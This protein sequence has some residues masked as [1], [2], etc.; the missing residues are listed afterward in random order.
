MLILALGS[1]ALAGCGTT[2]HHHHYHGGSDPGYARGGGYQH[3]R[4]RN[5]SYRRSGQRVPDPPPPR[6]HT[7]H[8]RRAKPSVYTPR[9]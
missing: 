4:Y 9:Y 6:T 7:P 8:H 5:Q 2:V 1:F 3:D